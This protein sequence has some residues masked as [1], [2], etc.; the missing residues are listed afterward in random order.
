M[1][2]PDFQ[3]LMLP[4]L[5]AVA[6]GERQLQELVTGIA[7][8][9]GLSEEARS[10]VL[11]SGKQTRFANR[12]GWASSYLTQAGLLHR[13]RRA[14]YALTEE[15]QKV[16]A[17]K[18]TRIDMAYLERFPAYRAFRSQNSENT[19]AVPDPLTIPSTEETPDEIIRAAHTQITQALAQELLD[20]IQAA[21]PK[22]FEELIVDLLVRMGYGNAGDTS[23]A[24]GQ[25][26]DDGVDGVINLDALGV[27]QVFFQAKRYG[28]GTAVGP[29]AMRDFFGALAMKDVTKGIF[30][31][32]SHFT[33]SAR[34]TAEKLSKR[35]VL[36]DGPT[37]SRLLIR[38][39]V[40]CRVTDTFPVS[41]VDESYFE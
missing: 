33:A 7:D 13:P 37:L 39:S 25:S 4:V 34:D 19:V 18:P 1:T 12:I 17:E 5:S 6:S 38:H 9:L 10:E 26:G 8:D 14:T 20:R 30:V 11:P 40:G 27:D 31:T 21:S 28:T 23:R 32:T 22:F 2:V 24:I 35:I 36:I 3:T 41:V 29:G 16:L 15:G